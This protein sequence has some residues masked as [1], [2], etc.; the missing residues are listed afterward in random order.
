M[1]AIMIKFQYHSKL[2]DGISPH[3]IKN[4]KY[5]K[6]RAIFEA[7][8]KAW[9]RRGWKYFETSEDRK[10]NDLSKAVKYRLG[11]SLDT[12]LNCDHPSKSYT[13][14]YGINSHQVEY[15]IPIKTETRLCH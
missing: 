10:V 6:S 8:L 15:I 13:A 9:S 11:N 4:V 7:L 5:F 1:G 2:K 3:P 12:I 14:F